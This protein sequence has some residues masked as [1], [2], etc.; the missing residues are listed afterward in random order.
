M[1]KLKQLL[2]EEYKSQSYWLDPEGKFHP[3]ATR[4]PT[5]FRGWEELSPFLLLKKYI[6]F[7]DFS[8][9]LYVDCENL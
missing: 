5:L 2:E 4:K 6:D 7:C 9:Y 1:I 8:L 3:G